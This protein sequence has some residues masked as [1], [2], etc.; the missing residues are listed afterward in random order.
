M[1]LPIYLYGQPVLRKVAEDIT[2]DYPELKSL[3]ESMFDTMHQAEGIGL[4]A[5]QVGLAIRLVV[6]DL[7]V[8]SEDFPEFKDFRR[9]YINAHII[10]TSDETDTM[11][12]G[13][14]SLPGIHEKVTRPSRIHVQYLDENFVEH[15]EWVEGYLARVMQHEF[16]HLEGKVFSDRI[17]MLRRQ[18]NKT[19]LGN[20]AKGRVA[21]G[22]KTKRVLR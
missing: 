20:L 6:V 17:S 10:E 2:P 4:A 19:K 3:I 9:V 16:D 5:P 11:E 12:E 18:M 13:C 22:Y 14:L 7:D 8:L 1:I 21:C 15:D